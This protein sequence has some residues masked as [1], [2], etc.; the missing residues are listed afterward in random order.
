MGR[1]N[2]RGLPSHRTKANTNGHTLNTL[3]HTRR[4]KERKSV[5]IP[6]TFVPQF[7]ED[8]DGRHH[9]AKEIRRRVKLLKDH[10]GADS[11]QRDLLCQR[12]AFLSVVLETMEITAAR[13]GELDL[14]VWTQGV[15]ALNGLLK[16]LGLD[17][18]VRKAGNL[19]SYLEDRG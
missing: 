10:A 12:A 13:D 1:Q 19:K 15:N 6:G 3:P 17:R 11:Y 16:S 7:W 14:G 5:S 4:A 8:L 18:K 9:I 2:D